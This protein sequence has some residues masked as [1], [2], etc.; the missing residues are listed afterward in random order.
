MFKLLQFFKGYKISTIIAPLLKLLEA[1]FELIIPLVVAKIIDVGI[2]T[3][4]TAYIIKMGGIMLGLGALGLGF[5]L[6]CQY[7]AARAS[8]GF[9]TNIRR[10]LYGKINS[11]GFKELDKFGTPSLV[12]RITSDVNQA[13]QGA[14][15]FIRLVL[16][17]PIIT[18]G[19]IIM[20]MSIDMRMSVIF[21]AMS[22]IMSLALYLVMRT[23]N[24]LYRKI[25]TQLDGVSRLTRTNLEGTRVVRA[26]SKE[27]TA[28][29]Q[30]NNATSALE[31]VSTKVS[32]ISTLLNPL[33]Y[34][35]INI[36]IIALLW[37][38]SYHVYD[39]ALSQGQIIALVNYLGQVL[40][41]LVVFANLAT[42]FSKAT[43]SANRI[44]EVLNCPVSISENTQTAFPAA[45]ENA[46]KISFNNVNFSYTDGANT[47]S[48]INFSINAGDT[49]GIIGATG[50]GKSTL[51]SL[52]PR[53]YDVTSGEIKIDG[54]NI[55][56]LPFEYFRRKIGV[57][58]QKAVLF[59]GTIAEN[60]RFGAP[61]ATDEELI[62]AL[63]IAQ[64]YDFIQQKQGL[65]TYVSRGGTNFSGGQRQRLTIARALVLKPEILIFDDSLSALDY[66]TASRL[67]KA[68]KTLQ[69][70]TVI[71]VSQRATSIKD[72]DQIIVLD[73][74]VIVGAG[75][76]NALYQACDIYK[77]IVDSQTKTTE[78][79]K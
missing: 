9:G 20:A 72:A 29:S 31:K 75:K 44:S 21:I 7:L 36:S 4:D 56:D 42:T 38:G 66:L 40:L 55:K 78:A 59:S 41:A 23:S 33:S 60:L 74:G 77:E 25:Q 11:F 24:R 15:M 63:K 58:L 2:A 49:V 8:L 62:D 37:L 39:G 19:A 35:I 34:A 26:F 28:L 18:V 17:A 43:A 61:N 54:N 71:N 68:L 48:D 65:S 30:F 3:G 73:N 27:D 50:S 53:F 47:L 10:A 69:G 46:P 13:Q 76:H 70:L 64:A 45:Q 51:I 32:I 12:T 79:T 14:S 52:I 57:A 16:R 22:L 5:S 6:T 1:V 67:A